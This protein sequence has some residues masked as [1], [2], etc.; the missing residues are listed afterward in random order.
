MRFNKKRKSWMAVISPKSLIINV[1]FNCM[2]HD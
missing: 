1:L 2:N